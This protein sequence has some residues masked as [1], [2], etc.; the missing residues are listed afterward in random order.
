M[1]VSCSTAVSSRLKYR[2]P[3]TE[4]AAA[5]LI[6]NLINALST[7]ALLSFPSAFEV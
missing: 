2:D 4:W 1:Q 5:T 3:L 7:L 6:I